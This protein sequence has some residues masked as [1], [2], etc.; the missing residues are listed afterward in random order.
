[1][2]FR[3]LTIFRISSTVIID[4]QRVYIYHLMVTG[5]RSEWKAHHPILI[6]NSIVVS[7]DFRDIATAF[8]RC[9][10]KERATIFLRLT[11]LLFAKAESWSFP[12]GRALV[13]RGLDVFIDLIFK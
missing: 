9:A 3:N 4:V 13:R 10:H 8:E 1:M 7:I 5:S 12:A 2:R 11:R 6:V